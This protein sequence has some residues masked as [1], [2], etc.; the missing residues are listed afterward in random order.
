MPLGS[1]LHSVSTSPPP[2]RRYAPAIIN[3]PGGNYGYPHVCLPPQDLDNYI[4]TRAPVTFLQELRGH[5][6][7]SDASYMY[8]GVN[9]RVWENIQVHILAMQARV[10]Y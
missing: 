3:S 2:S 7:V 1:S 4:R 5:L 6:T 10:L 9:I 8:T